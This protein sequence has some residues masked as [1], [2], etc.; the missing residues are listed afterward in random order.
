MSA[1]GD[2][3]HQGACRTLED[4]SIIITLQRKPRKADVKRLRRRDTEELKSIRSQAAR[5]AADNFD[6]LVD[7]EPKVPEVLN[8]RA[9][10]TGAPS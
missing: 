10:E 2:R 9:A 5:W 4:R 1:K 3:H 6:H 7:P 8:D